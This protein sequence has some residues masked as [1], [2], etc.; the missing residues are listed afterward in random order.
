[1]SILDDLV[2]EAIPYNSNAP[3]VGAI[4][5][6]WNNSPWGIIGKKLEDNLNPSTRDEDRAAED[7]LQK[8]ISAY[9]GLQSPTL[10]PPSSAKFQDVGLPQ[11]NLSYNLD[12]PIMAALAEQGPSAY[13]NISTDPRLKND[14]MASLDAL[15]A[16][17]DGGGL[18]AAD[19]ANL[20]KVQSDV[21]LADRGRREAILQNAN[22]RGMGGGGNEL[23]ALLDSSQAATDRANQS[24]LDIAGMAQDRALEAIMQGGN[25]A[26]NLRSQDF[27]EQ[28]KKAEATDAIK[29]FN[30]AN[31]NSLNL[32]NAGAANNFA[33]NKA[34]G[35]LRAAT[36]NLSANQLRAQNA[37]AVANNNV[38]RANDVNDMT[39][40]L[41]QQEFNNNLGIAAGKSGAYEKG[42]D[43]YTAAGDRKA[44]K[45]SGQL[46]GLLQG[47]ALAASFL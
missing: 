40:K 27:N 41:Q 24:G 33:A 4:E 1:M 43:F 3:S 35:N 6:L 9:D 29:R 38:S 42:V 5:D 47:G 20:N 34:E 36:G 11:G 14:Q 45:G 28:A 22:A 15:K 2:N 23:L 32:A 18:T 25:L 31:A 44:K 12:N 21:A 37:Q 19:K 13:D 30:A 39:A 10:L 46:S 26:G 17:A 7:Y 8:G 16:I